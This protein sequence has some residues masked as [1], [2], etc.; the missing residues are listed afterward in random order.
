MLQEAK[1][2]ISS[3]DWA[4]PIAE[5]HM[6][7]GAGGALAVFL[8]TFVRGIGPERDKHLWVIVGDLPSAYLVVDRASDAV[9][10]LSIYC[11]LMEEWADAVLGGS[12]LDDVFPVDAPAT[13][14]N[15]GMLLSRVGFIREKIIPE[16]WPH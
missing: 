6:R 11:E 15:A 7:I 8:V 4:P 14:E 13:R 10:A 2:Y 5:V 12:S 1:Q 9:A 3:F 16:F